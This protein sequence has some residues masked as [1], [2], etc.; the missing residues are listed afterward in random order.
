MTRPT[1]L[2]ICGQRVL[3]EFVNLEDQGLCGKSNQARRLIQVDQSLAPE[4]MLE[5][6]FHEVVHFILQSNGLNQ[7]LGE[8]RDEMVAQSVGLGIAQFLQENKLP[9]LKGG[10]R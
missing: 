2:K 3:L 6:I 1:Y 9:T 4:V 7:V 10:L 8:K 5:T